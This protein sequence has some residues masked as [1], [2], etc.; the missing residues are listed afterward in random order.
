VAELGDPRADRDRH[1]SWVV[2]F[3]VLL[4]LAAMFALGCVAGSFLTWLSM[5]GPLGPGHGPG[6]D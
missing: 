4:A 2:P 6:A 3:W 1:P 5:L